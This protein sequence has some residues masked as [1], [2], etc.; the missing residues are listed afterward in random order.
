MT[1]MVRYIYIFFWQI[2]IYIFLNNKW[3]DIIFTKSYIAR[4]NKTFMYIP[5][6]NWL[7]I[8]VSKL[9]LLNK[10]HTHDYT[11]VS[12]LLAVTKICSYICPLSLIIVKFVIRLIC[13]RCFRCYPFWRFG[14]FITNFSKRQRP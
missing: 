12:I 11:I 1:K 6:L 7:K 14:K 4:K 10:T 5:Y 9:L 8:W 2:D 13:K 3:F